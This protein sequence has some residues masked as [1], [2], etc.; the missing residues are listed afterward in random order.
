[1]P[2]KTWD[3]FL[4]E[5][6]TSSDNI[7]ETI[8]KPAVPGIYMKS[9]PGHTNPIANEAGQKKTVWRNRPQQT[10]P[11]DNNIPPME[12]LVRAYKEPRGAL[13]PERI[14]EKQ[15]RALS[16]KHLLIMIRD[17]EIEL[18]Q[19]KKEKENLILAYRAGLIHGQ[20]GQT[21]SA[22]A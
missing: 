6:Q 14:T 12:E 4:F 19:E 2:V 17:L 1:M 8:S 5:Q 10:L 16:K 18:K 7:Q 13:G 21:V 22:N 3:A 11:A 20:K 15:L 9:I